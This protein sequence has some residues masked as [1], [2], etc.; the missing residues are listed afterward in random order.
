MSYG[1]PKLHAN[2]QTNGSVG[3]APELPLGETKEL[4]SGQTLHNAWTQ[5]GA[6]AYDFH[7]DTITTPTKSMLDAISKCTLMDD[8][9]TGDPTTQALESYLAELSGQE[10]GLLVMSGTMGNQVAIRSHLTA[11]PHTV[12]CDYRAHIANYE[13]GGIS[14]LSGAQLITVHP[15]NNHHLTLEDVKKHCI[16]NDDVHAAPTQVISLENT[17]N[18]LIMPLDEVKRIAQFAQ[19]NDI[20]LHLDGARI[21]E[22]VAAGAGSMTEYCSLF[23]SV[24]MCLSKGLGAPI[25]S[26]LVGN[27]RFITI[28]KRIRKM[29]GGATRQAGIISAAARVAVEE[30]FGRGPNGEGGRLRACHERAARLGRAWEEKGGKLVW[31]VETNM[32]WLDLEGSGVSVKELTKAAD[33]EGVTVHSGRIVVHH[34]SAEEAIEGLERALGRVL[35]REKEAASRTS[36][37]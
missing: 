1:V 18:G 9:Y 10:A 14:T 16:I 23:D 17:L 24:S 21:W 2:K 29:M 34:Q 6:N 36:D 15:S 12:L 13:A 35:D 19:E 5:P 8:V 7:S 28:A 30:G 3:H 33:E 4:P 20:R 37:K 31:P 22:A 25:G 26:V 11:P 27:K 32:V